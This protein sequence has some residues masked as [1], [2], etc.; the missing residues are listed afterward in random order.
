VNYDTVLVTLAG[1]LQAPYAM[2]S[3]DRSVRFRV[4]TTAWG[5]RRQG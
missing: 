4:A 1:L 3:S 5:R 2:W